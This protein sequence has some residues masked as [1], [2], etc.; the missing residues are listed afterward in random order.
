MLTAQRHEHL[1]TALARDGRIVAKEA[2]IE[3]GAT[4]DTIRRDLRALAEQGLL[5]RVYG[6]ALPV[7]QADRPHAE[8][9]QV[10]VGSKRRVARASLQLLH[11][12]TTLLLDA[13]TTAVEVARALPSDLRLTVITPGP[14]VAIALAEHPL[15]EI[16][17]IGGTVSRHSMVSGGALAAEALRRV[18]ADL[19]FIGVTG[20]H[21]EAGLTTGSAD[22]AA[23]KR[24]MAERAAET[25]VL[26]SAEKIGAA[27][28]HPVLEFGE[29]TGFVLD[30][31]A[32]LDPPLAEAFGRAGARVIH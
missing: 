31:D 19:C 29:V 30:P 10:S 27:S 17:L 3:L 15:V 12:G 32:P 24:A 8:R 4:D 1:I 14:L 5:Q 11:P 13:G 25:Y 7:S 23:T 9:Q 6:G 20:V 26:A 28:A 18:G 21:A 16:V 22:D 2:A